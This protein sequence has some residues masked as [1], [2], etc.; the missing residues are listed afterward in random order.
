MGKEKILFVYDHLGEKI[1]FTSKGLIYEFVKPPLQKK[2]NPSEEEE[3]EEKN[4][5]ESLVKV[6]VLM[7][8]LDANSSV[9]INSSAKQSHYFTYGVKEYN[10]STFKKITYKNIYKNIDIEYWIPTDKTHGIKYNIILHTGAKVQDI[11]M[12]YSGAIKNMTI[13]ETGDLLVKTRLENIMERAPVS[14]YEDKTPVA[15]N[16][17]L[18]KNIV[19]FSL[20]VAP[21]DSRDL[22]IDPWIT[23]ITTLSNNNY[24]YDVDYDVNGNTFIYGGNVAGGSRCKEAMYNST[25][26][27]IWT[28]SGLL[29]TPAPVWN[30]GTTWSSNFKVHKLTGKTYVSRNQGLPNVIRLDVSG[31]YDNFIGPATGNILEVWNMEINCNGDLI[32]YGG[33]ATSGEIINT[34]TGVISLLTGFN[35]T[36]TGC[37]QD[38]LSNAIDDAGN[39]FVCYSGHA[40]LNNNLAQIS[41]TFTNTL[42]LAPSGFNVFTY[43]QSKTLYVGATAGNAVAFNALAVNGNYLYYYDGSNLAA[44]NKTNGSILGSV[45]ITGLTGRVQGGIAVDDCD[46]IYIGGNGSVLSYSFSGSTFSV[47]PSISLGTTVTNQYVYD[48]QLDRINKV[49]HVTGSGFVGT[50]SA[51]SSLTCNSNYCNCMLPLITLNTASVTCPNIGASTV[52]IVGIPGPYTYSWTPTSQTTSIATGLSPGTYT[53][54]ITS[55][56]CNTSYSAETTFTAANTISLTIS[57]TSITCANLGS[58]TL[59]PFGI[60]P[61]YSYTWM[62]TSQNS[63]VASGLSPGNYTVSVFSGGCNFNYTTTTYFNSLIPLTGN[64][65]NSDSVTCFGAA[66]GTG[67]ITGIAGGSGNEFYFWGNGLNTYTTAYT[68][69]LT[70]GIWSVSATDVLTGC[71]IFQTFYVSQP[72]QLVLQLSSN[73]PTNCVGTTIVLTGTNAGGRQFTS[74]PAYNYT[75]TGGPAINTHSVSEIVAGVHMYTLSSSDANNCL[76]SNSIPVDFIPNPTLSVSNVS[77]CPLETA[78]LIAGGASSYTWNSTFV[79]ANFSAS[80]LA[81]QQFTVVGSALS[82]TASATASVILKP[83]PVPFIQSNSPRCNGDNLTLLGIGGVSYNWVGPTSYTSVNQ[84]N[85]IGLVAP[86]NAGVYNLTVTAANTCSAS[87]SATVVVNPTPTLSATG[88]TVC[89]TQTLNFSVMALT[90]SSYKWT[91]PQ[92][93]NSVL[94]NPSI[95]N[96]ATNTSGTYTIKITSIE[97]CTNT[98]ITHASVVSPPSL[99]ISLSSGSICSQGFNGSTTSLTLNTS[100]ANTYTLIT[101]SNVSN[102]NPAGPSATLTSVAPFLSGVITFTLEGSNGICTSISTRNFTILPNPTITISSGSPAICAKQNFTYTTTGATNYFWGSDVTGLSLL[103]Q[104]QLA[105]ASPSVSS[106]YSV[107]GSSVGCNSETRHSTITVNAIPVFSLNPSTPTICLTG[108]I[109]LE[110]LGTAD[111]YLW[112]PFAGLNNIVGSTVIASPSTEQTYTVVGSLNSC[113]A[114][115][116]ITV[117]VFALPTPMINVIKDKVCVNETITLQG[118]GGERYDWYSPLGALPNNSN[119]GQNVSFLANHAEFN[120]TYSL[121]VTDK[122]GCKALATTLITV[123]SLPTSY[124]NSTITRVCV[125]FGADFNW[126]SVSDSSFNIDIK[127]R[128]DTSTFYGK[129]FSYPFTKPGSYVITGFF[130]DTIT[131]C[132]NTGTF[133]V[134]AH[135]QPKADFIYNPEHPV[136]DANEVVFTNTSEGELQ[137]K[138]NWY[139]MNND[140]LK[141]EKEICFYTFKEAG[142]YPVALVVSDVWGCSDTVVKNIAVDED[143]NLFVPNVFTPNGDNQNDIFLPIMRGVKL[144]ELTIFNRWGEL[145]FTTTDTQSGWNGYYKGQIC[146][147]A[148]YTWK[149]SLSTKSGQMKQLN[150]HITI[151]K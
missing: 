31:N 90:G 85:T 109:T 83:V 18:H 87:T 71:K 53:V 101:P 28:F 73:T 100:G 151:S 38:I 138:W 55:L 121:V 117:S 3:E 134:T 67:N 42:W 10:S 99:S 9:E 115:A 95:I 147:N 123:Y 78:T 49:L 12:K 94:Q 122:N 43:L 102:S 57:S 80:P 40:S 148:V 15:S 137:Q 128:L 97:G 19:S 145:M 29:V 36:V 2:I 113:T 54:A 136:E 112:N 124:I 96:P 140:G 86:I 139:F 64:F 116:A 35:P 120:G 118:T 91:G 45:T 127:W 63:S 104:G 65:S 61:P 27:L 88:S 135:P 70:A 92:N 131:S 107:Y 32:I 34:N 125:P 39:I 149:I 22:I 24:G 150:G 82:C 16:F 23:A 105:I 81:N 142:I 13:L 47:M 75:W 132:S 74:G 84:S 62:P 20:S 114:S 30:S 129:K 119:I 60:L 37:C 4:E 130:K 110:A 103:N 21:D 108:K 106:I 77:I 56:S 7:N 69:S 52:N 72:P 41:P 8:W 68:N 1:S 59:V 126:G 6:R 89:T 48:V 79:G 58:A 111:N 50:Y 76:T 98:A 51:I 133:L 141:S 26:T 17:V 66:T 25:G 33:G 46:H 44:Y 146:Q 14:F 11:K 144:Y 5:E 93:Y 143:F